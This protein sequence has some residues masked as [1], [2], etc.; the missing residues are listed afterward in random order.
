MLTRGTLLAALALVALVAAPVGAEDEKKIDW[1]KMLADKATSVVSI[2]FVTQI[3]VTMGG[4]VVQDAEQ[5]REVRGTMINDKGLI[6]TASGNMTPRMRPNPRFTVEA[7]P[8]RDIKI[9]FGN[10]EEEFEAEMVATDKNLDLAFVQIMKLGD[11]KISHVSL[12]DVG[13]EP[14]IG[15]ELWTASRLPRGFDNAPVLGRIMVTATVEKPRRMWA[16]AGTVGGLGMPAYDEDGKVVGMLASQEGSEG[17]GEGGGARPFL[18]PMKSVERVLKMAE[19]RASKALTAAKEAEEE[20]DGD[21][22]GEEGEHGDKE[23]G[24]S[25][26]H[27]DK[28]DGD[29]EKPEEAP[30]KK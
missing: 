15:S 16:I 8:P 9:L 4:Q 14:K 5:N 23:D 21:E 13:E 29:S 12:T 10:E 22:D 17:V 25:E 20:E 27:G 2:K 24:D 1:E 28:E 3:K 26:E 18:L 11:K 7:S 6:I 19:E 30:E